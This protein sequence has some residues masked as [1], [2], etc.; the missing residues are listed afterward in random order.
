MTLI[1]DNDHV[2]IILDRKLFMVMEILT[3]T[4]GK[5]FPYRYFCYV[6]LGLIRFKTSFTSTN[7]FGH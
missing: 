3:S 5:T 2:E 1:L 6:Y 7:I 4:L